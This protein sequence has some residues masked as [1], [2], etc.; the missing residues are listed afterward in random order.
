MGGWGAGGLGRAVG[1]LRDV[2]AHV[3]DGEA[4]PLV[5]LV[6][7]VAARAE[8][9]HEEQVG[10]RDERGVLVRHEGVRDRGE[11]ARLVHDVLH[12][13]PGAQRHSEGR[14]SLLEP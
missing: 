13:P 4:S 3:V 10:A 12:L 14:S 5:E 6:E 9:H 1:R 7:E 2:D 11:D 8:L